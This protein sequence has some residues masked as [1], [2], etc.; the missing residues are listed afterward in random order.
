MSYEIS[1][2]EEELAKEF[3]LRRVRLDADQ[4]REAAGIVAH[5][6]FDRLSSYARMSEAMPFSPEHS[7]SDWVCYTVAELF[8]SER[9][10]IKP[11]ELTTWYDEGLRDWLIAAHLRVAVKSRGE[12]KA[13]VAD[14]AELFAPPGKVRLSRTT[15]TNAWKRL[16]SVV[17]ESAAIGTLKDLYERI[18][19]EE[20]RS[21]R[22]KETWARWLEKYWSRLETQR[23]LSERILDEELGPE[24]K[25]VLLEPPTPT[26]QKPDLNFGPKSVCRTDE[27]GPL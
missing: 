21:R 27:Q 16:K 25:K 4:E 19:D 11:A 2:E 5:L 22:L 17:T 6:L 10:T 20:E 15:V 1:K 18:E 7:L 3:L 14:A 26:V 12:W 24:V 9:I 13:A 8:A 23:D